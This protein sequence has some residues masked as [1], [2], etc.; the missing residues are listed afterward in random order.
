MKSVL[1]LSIGVLAAGCMV[2]PT[3]GTW[4]DDHT[5]PIDFNLYAISPSAKM[6]LECTAPWWIGPPD[7]HE[8]AHVTASDHPLI[9][10]DG[11]SIYTANVSKVVPESC[12][13]SYHGT[14]VVT[15]I[16]P[17]QDGWNAAVFDDAGRDCAFHEVLVEHKSPV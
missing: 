5:H 6:T 16:R 15:D 1:F 14:E 12:W 8:F 7:Y 17:K 4:V 3:W 13:G 9:T 2:G 11:G 10:V